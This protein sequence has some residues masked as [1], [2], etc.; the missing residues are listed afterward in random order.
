MLRRWPTVSRGSSDLYEDDGRAPYASINF[1]IAH[2][3]FTLHDL[4]S[5]NDKHNEANGE[6]NRDG[7]NDNNSW[8]CGAEGP[9]EDDGI[10]AL[11]EQQKRNFLATML[12][13]QGVPMICGGDEMGR[14]QDGNNNA[15]CQD[16]EISWHNWDMNENARQLLDFTS[17]LIAARRQHPALRRRNFFL[18]RPIRGGES[19]DVT[20]LRPDGGEMTDEE[21]GTGWV[22]CFGM[23]LSGDLGEIDADGSV[24]E[25]DD[26]MVLLNAD[27]EPQLFKLPPVE[28]SAVWQA[29]IDTSLGESNPEIGEYRMAPRSIVLLRRPRSQS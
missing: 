27:H 17:E 11:R 9:T 8:N 29:V 18:G 13:S 22:R 2:D 23:Q 12:F 19:K 3:G 10:N 25:D 26:L 15:Y 14:T 24:I 4:V 6:D 21:W 7:A 20:W 16:N 28:Q 1:V 5:Y